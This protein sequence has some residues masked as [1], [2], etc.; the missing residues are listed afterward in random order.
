M[1]KPTELEM[2][3]LGILWRQGPL[4]VREILPRMPDGKAR[5][6][7]SILSVMQV[8]EK[9]GYLTRTREGL[10]D[11]WSPAVEE[12]RILGPFMKNLVAHI[13]GGDAR[14]ALQYLLKESDVDAAEQEA[15][16]KLIASHA[17]EPNATD[18]TDDAGP[19]PKQPEH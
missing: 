5:A 17:G 13:F 15:I 10:T 7:T 1:E 12:K 3:V 9:K 19:Q 11:R 14:H 4:T 2:Q 8:M 6:Y 18:K 16:R